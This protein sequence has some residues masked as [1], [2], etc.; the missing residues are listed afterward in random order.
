MLYRPTQSEQDHIAIFSLYHNLFCSA[1][2]SSISP[3]RKVKHFRHWRLLPLHVQLSSAKSTNTQLAS[4]QV[5][6]LRCMT[7]HT[8]ELFDVVFLKIIS[9]IKYRYRLFIILY[10]YFGIFPEKLEK[11]TPLGCLLKAVPRP[12]RTV[13]QYNLTPSLYMHLFLDRPRFLLP[14]ISWP[15]IICLEI[16]HCAPI[17]ANQVH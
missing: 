11:K 4:N 13:L 14:I 12:T 9:Q 10:K 5:L 17:H 6:L 3:S 7:L 1:N 2:T 15:Q 16:L 8:N